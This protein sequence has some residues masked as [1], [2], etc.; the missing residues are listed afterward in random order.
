L[1][2]TFFT[3]DRHLRRGSRPLLFVAALLLSLLCMP[4]WSATPFQ[5]T[6]PA[7]RVEYWQKRLVEITDQLI[8]SRSLASVRLVFL[9]DSITDF[10]GLAGN[11]WVT[12]ATGGRSVW[13]ESFAGN[14]AQNLGLNLGI[15][16]DRTEHVLYRL[17]PQSAGGLGELDAPGLHPEF[18]VLLVGINNTWDPETPV[19]ASVF[20]GIR[21]VISA[22]HDRQPKAI[23]I[24]ESLLPTNDALKN[25]ETVLPVNQRLREL[26]ASLPF[27]NYVVYLDLYSKFVDS[28][29]A[30]M[31]GYFMDGLHPNESGYR[32]WRDALLPCID[33]A[34]R[35]SAAAKQIG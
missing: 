1:Q 35:A 18:V 2:L 32:I 8:D 9:G 3:I 27:A 17:L 25:R 28:S 7:V 31:S 22:V 20:D 24:L 13:N 21:A 33:N 16:G 11:P 34:R 19:A 5:A 12:G 23:V 10:W 14:P 29:G 15:S 26:T 6:R 4:A 30:Q